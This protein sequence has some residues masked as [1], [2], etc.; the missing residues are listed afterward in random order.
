VNQYTELINKTK[1][2]TRLLVDELHRRK[3]VYGDIVLTTPVTV[4]KNYTPG[5][6]KETKPAVSAQLWKTIFLVCVTILMLGVLSVLIW[7]AIVKL[8]LI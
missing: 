8:K 5:L 7:L 4:N 6:S 3:E 1:E 2:S